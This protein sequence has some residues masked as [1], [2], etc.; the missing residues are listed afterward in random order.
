MERQHPGASKRKYHVAMA[1]FVD[2]CY[3]LLANF[4]VM[5]NA[6][7]VLGLFLNFA[8][9]HFLQHIDNIALETQ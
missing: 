4:V 1:C 6:K 3:S 7:T 5:L 2:G 8:A 9:L